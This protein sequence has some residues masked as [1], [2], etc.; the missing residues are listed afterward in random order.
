MINEGKTVGAKVIAIGSFSVI[1]YAS[2]LK[3]VMFLNYTIDYYF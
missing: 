1:I 3:L 2:S